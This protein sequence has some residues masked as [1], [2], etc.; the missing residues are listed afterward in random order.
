MSYSS[1]TTPALVGLAAG[2]YYVHIESAD[3][4]T[5]PFYIVDIRVVPPACGDGIV[6]VGS[7]EQCDHGTNNGTPTD[8]CSATCQINS[9]SYLNE[10]EPN[11]TQATANSIDGH[12]GAVGQINPA[13]DVDWYSVSVTVGGSSIT[14]EIGDGFGACPGNFDSQLALY[15]PS[16]ALLASDTSGGVSPCSKITPAKYTGASNLP[17]GKYALKV[18]RITSSVQ[19]SYVL[20]VY[21]LPPGCGDG[22]LEPGEQCDPGPV[23][24]PGCSATCQLTGDF[25]PETE[26][27]GSPATANALGMHAGFIGAISPVGDLDYYSFQ[28]PGPNSLVFIQTSDGLGGCPANFDSLL[29]LFDPTGTPLVTDDN[30]GVG[31]CSRIS[32]Q[33][34][35]QAMNLTAGTYRARVEFKGDN[36][37]C[38]EYVV[39]VSVQQPGCGDGIVETGEQCDDG[40]LNGTTGAGCSA[41]CTSLAPWEIRPNNTTATATPQWSGFSTWKGSISPV[42]DHDYFTF[43]LA[44]A[45]KVTLTTH[46]VDNATACSSDT[47]LYLVNAANTQLTYDDDSGPGPGDPSSG[48]CSKIS[49]YSLAAGTYYA[50]VQRYGDTKVIPS[51]QLDLLVQ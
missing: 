35:P 6:Q 42:G 29:T 12:A 11:T 24:V 46:D 41:T 26:P 7:G 4:I 43:T 22:I 19:T 37:T 33:L 13:G 34:Y 50:W 8:G 38:Q 18:S 47:V 3:L 5:I 36:A 17:I 15:S 51:Y 2:K 1:T 48:R 31:L 40:P 10:T 30:G 9:G 16:S 14:A 44:A 28:V 45:G 23:M 20:K 25:I 32:P 27:N 39:T 21:V 49:M